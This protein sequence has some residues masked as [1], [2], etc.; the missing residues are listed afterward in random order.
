M[1]QIFGTHDMDRM[2][3]TLR[4]VPVW[5][6]GLWV[7]FLALLGVAPFA[8]FMSE[9]TIVRG[10]LAGRAFWAA[11]LFLAAV[12]V[13]FVGAAR[14][15]IEMAFGQPAE[16]GTVAPAGARAKLIVWSTIAF[17]L[18]LGLWLPSP[19]ARLIA[20]AARVLEGS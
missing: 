6:A 12:A 17:L 2:R 11:G 9:F 13:V 4:S 7:S 14:H 19:L 16:T 1:G 10:A 5:G 18:V 3:G 8:L 15:A 20:D